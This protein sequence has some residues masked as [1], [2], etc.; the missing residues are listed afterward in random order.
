M[1]GLEPWMI[2]TAVTLLM[3][4]AAAAASLDAATRRT[5]PLLSA[6]LGGL[7]LP[8]AGVVALSL[9]RGEDR[10]G[11]I[12]IATILFGGASLPLCLAAG[13]ATIWLRRQ[14]FGRRP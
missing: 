14:R 13:A 10:H 5:R 8:T 7:L 6:V 1:L 2:V 12:L 4:T 9:L 11:Y 3:V